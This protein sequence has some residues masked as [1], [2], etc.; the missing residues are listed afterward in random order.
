MRIKKI[1][2]YTLTVFLVNGKKF[3]I[4][5]YVVDGHGRGVH[6]PRTY[7]EWYELNEKEKLKVF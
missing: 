2:L 1:N 7:D 5:G 6:V 3:K 4:H